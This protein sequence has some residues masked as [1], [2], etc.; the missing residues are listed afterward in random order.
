MHLFASPRLRGRG[1]ALAVA[2]VV[3]L[4]LA[5]S[6]AHSAAAQSA[7]SIPPIRILL[8]GIELPLD[9]EPFFENQRTL[10]PFRTISEALGVNVDYDSK[11]GKVWGNGLGHRVEL[12]WGSKTA[13]LDG[14]SV[15]LDAAARVVNNRTMIPLRFFSESFDATVNWHQENRTI[16]IDAPPRRL[17]TLGFYAI[18][19][20]AER[21][22]VGRFDKMGYGW[23]RLTR[24][25]YMDFSG[26]EY[27]WPDPAGDVTGESLLAEAKA[28][29][30]ERYLMVW[31]VDGKGDVSS[32][33]ADDTRLQRAAQEMAK[34]A[35]ER[36]FDGL[37][38]D[39]EGLGL[40]GTPDQLAQVR[41]R[42]TKLAAA[43]AQAA[44]LRGGKLIVAVP[45][46]NGSYKGYDLKAIAAVADRV[47]LMSY[48]YTDQGPEPTDL[49]HDG[50]KQALQQVP[51][52]KLLL[53]V[54]AY[55][56]TPESLVPK[57]GLAKRYSLAGVAVWR[58]GLMGEPF[59]QT[60]KAQTIMK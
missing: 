13:L 57:V 25:G 46:P 5:L 32:V 3:A 60:L 56:E 38:L 24:D 18:R 55:S 33:L 35:A 8:D 40:T 30:T 20:F 51:R 29:G 22:Y 11:L 7:S 42:F 19:S 47:M 45:P 23:A 43:T 28:A 17:E 12:T 44:K 14:E 31:A 53:G 50:L 39:L 36:S 1:L 37:V 48:E 6:P 21:G 15:P 2:F 54:S 26:S 16:T 9:S 58:L 4:G 27:R 34:A 41:E 52:E 49:V 59:L 10:V